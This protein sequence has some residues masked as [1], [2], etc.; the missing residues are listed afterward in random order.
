MIRLE[1][2]KHVG[3][4]GAGTMGPGMALV[5]SQYGYH[6]KLYSRRQET[7]DKAE[8]VV[9]TGLATMTE[10]GLLKREEVDPILGGV[11]LTDSLKEA[12]SEDVSGSGCRI[13]S[14]VA[15]GSWSRATLSLRPGS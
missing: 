2:I 13:T 15:K 5:F 7:R 1:E 4:I 12:A 3:V 9:R 6:V 11:V 8:S 10:L 14:T